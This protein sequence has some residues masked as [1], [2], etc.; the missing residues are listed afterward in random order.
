MKSELIR[1]KDRV[2]L[3]LRV[4]LAGVDAK[5]SPFVET[6]RSINVSGGGLCFE[7]RTR[8]AIGGRLTLHIQL[9]FRLRK[10]FAGRSEYGVRAVICR[11]EPVPEQKIFRVGARFLGEIEA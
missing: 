10:H 11:I 9:P 7:S 8:L 4:D 6:T 1:Q 2:P 5:G 3:H